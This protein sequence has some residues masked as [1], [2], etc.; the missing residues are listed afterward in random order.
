VTA[1]SLRPWRREVEVSRLG[2][3]VVAP[4]RRRIDEG[5]FARFEVCELFLI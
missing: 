4:V 1:A 5:V 2:M 3:I